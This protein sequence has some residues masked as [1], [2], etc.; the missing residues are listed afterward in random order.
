M[1]ASFS[2]IPNQRH[3]FPVKADTIIPSRAVQ[4]WPFERVESREL[5]PF[6]SVQNA[7]SVDENVTRVVKRLPCRKILDLNIP[8]ASRILPLR[9]CNLMP[10]LDVLSQA[11]LVGEV[12]EIRVDLLAPGEDRRPVG[13]WLKGVCVEMGMNVTSATDRLMYQINDASVFLGWSHLPWISVLEPG[14]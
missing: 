9:A 11:V 10:G 6:P 1:C 2:P 12:V 5:R 7:T 8:L 4:F 14:S 3:R 13:L